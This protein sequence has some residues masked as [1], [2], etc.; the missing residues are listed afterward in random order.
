M[1]DGIHMYE[2]EFFQKAFTHRVTDVQCGMDTTMIARV[3]FKRHYLTLVFTRFVRCS[4]L[5]CSISTRRTQH[6]NGG[7]PTNKWRELK[8]LRTLKLS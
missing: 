1:M 2:G 7:R 4:S 6:F 5:M 8:T 3:H